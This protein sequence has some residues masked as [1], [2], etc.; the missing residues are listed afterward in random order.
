MSSDILGRSHEPADPLA[1]WLSGSVDMAC[2]LEGVTHRETGLD[3]IEIA[4]EASKLGMKAVVLQAHDYCTAPIAAYLADA[5]FKDASITLCGS[6]ALN[7]TVGGLNVYAVEHTL[8]LAG[9]VVHMPTLSAVNFLRSQRWPSR[10]PAG[11]DRTGP[12][13]SVVD[14]RGR[15]LPEL[16][17]LL[18]IVAVRGG[19]LGAGFLH[20][21]E[22]L[23]LFEAARACGVTRLLTVDPVHNN[24]ARPEDVDAMLRQHAHIMVSAASN[25]RD[26]E[27]ALSLAATH[28]DRL[29]LGLHCR[30]RAPSVRQ[31]YVTALHA[32]RELGLG[33]MEI[34]R[35]IGDNPRRLLDLDE[36]VTHRAHPDG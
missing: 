28:P 9:K 32:W 23:A 31:Q 1:G 34:R 5:D 20:A 35:A 7:T 25:R 27:L 12:S 30:G 29:I 24:G 18:E 16:K 2:D 4:G 17:E 33:E 15:I 10:H 36:D 19:V 22:V 14:A 8:M 21:S 26:R 11:L 6:V 13:L 3:P